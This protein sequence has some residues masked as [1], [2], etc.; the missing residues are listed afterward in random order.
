LHTFLKLLSH[1]PKN[2][3]EEEKNCLQVNYNAYLCCLLGKKGVPN[4][5]ETPNEIQ[6][7]EKL[8]NYYLKR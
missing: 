4:K 8:D 2:F 1:R 7:N 5:K 6:Q 3:E